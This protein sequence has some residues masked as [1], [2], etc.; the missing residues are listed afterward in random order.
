MQTSLFGE[1]NQNQNVSRFQP[2]ADRLRPQTADQFLGREQIQISYPWLFSS[3]PTSVVLSGPPGC[4]KTSLAAILAKQYDLTF[5]SFSAVLSGVPELRKLIAH[6]ETQPEGS[7]LFIDEIHRFNKGQQDALLPYIEKGAFIFVGATTE[8]PK[9]CLN[10]ALLSRLQ[11]VELNPLSTSQLR[12][13]ARKAAEA[14]EIEL[15]EEIENILMDLCGCDSRKCL[16]ALELLAAEPKLIEQPEIFKNHLRSS[17]R[18]H[19]RAGDRHYDVIS[20]FIK[21]MRGSDPDAALLWLAVMIDGGEDPVFIARRQMIFASEDVGNADPRALMLATS[22]LEAVK[23]IGMP[24][25]R[26]ILSQT[27]CYLSSTVKSNRSYLALDKALDYVKQKPNLEIPDHLK[28]HPPEGAAKYLYPHD[29]PPGQC[30]QSYSNEK[31]P[32]FYEPSEIGQERF[33]KEQLSK[34]H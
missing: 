5:H 23:S 22:A 20:A 33:L 18:Y 15:P 26:I 11:L 6:I 10:P 21:S 24:E 12:Q 13:L 31:L 19:D 9:F 29:Y 32:R 1:T 34:K 7:L 14:L 2:L 30:K 3:K 8:N 27:T 28:N 17:A 4:G 25:A 16:N